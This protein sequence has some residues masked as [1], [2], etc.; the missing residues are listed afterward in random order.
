[1]GLREARCWLGF[2][3]RRT[4]LS[5]FLGYAAGSEDSAG[6]LPI[7]FDTTIVGALALSWVIV[8]VYQFF[9]SGESRVEIL[10]RWTRRLNQ[11]RRSGA[12]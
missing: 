4:S 5:R 6:A 11:P 8:I 2:D 10:F 3:F 1:M 7:A 12:F 9:L